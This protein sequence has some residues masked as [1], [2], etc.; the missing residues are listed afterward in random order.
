MS[1]KEKKRVEKVKKLLEDYSRL[2]P[3]LGIDEK[4]RERT[5]D[6]LLDDL[7]KALK[8]EKQLTRLPRK[9]DA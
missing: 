9:K 5:I 8:E 7:S 2:A 6:I 1:K 3:L 4:D